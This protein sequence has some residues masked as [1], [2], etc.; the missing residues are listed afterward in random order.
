MISSHDLGALRV[1]A[2]LAHSLPG[3]AV[4]AS[5]PDG[6]VLVEVAAAAAGRGREHPAAARPARRTVTPCEF[7]AAVGRAVARTAEG[8]RLAFGGLPAGVAPTVELV[9]PPGGAIWAGGRCRVPVEGRWW[10]AFASTLELDRAHGLGEEL[11]ANGTGLG[12]GDELRLRW[13][14]LTQVSMAYI[15]TAAAPGSDHERAVVDLLDALLARWAVDELLGPHDP[16][17]ARR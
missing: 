5:R 9:A 6:A 4:L 3:L 15:E 16:H 2:T 11:V 14:P 10:W 7:R 1:A 12:T 8:R 13:D 17:A